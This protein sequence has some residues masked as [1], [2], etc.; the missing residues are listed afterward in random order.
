MSSKKNKTEKLDLKNIREKLSQ[1]SGPQYWR[2]LEEIAETDGF[3]DFL[4]H[5]FPKNAD[6]WPDGL[7]RRHFLQLMGASLALVG[8][9]GCTQQPE[10]RIVPF[11]K[12]PEELIPGKPLFYATA[13]PFYGYAQGLLAESHDGRPTK[14]EGNPRHPASQGATNLFAQASV[15]DLYDPD[16]IDVIMQG[17]RVRTWERFV[18]ELTSE[19]ERQRSTGGKG[20]C[21]L[22]ET[23]TSPT[24]AAQISQLLERL[25]EARWVQYEPI[26]LDSLR[27]GALQAFGE[28]LNTVYRFDKADVVLSLDA[29]FM[30]SGP[31]AVRYARD[32]SARRKVE[33]NGTQP[34]RFYMIESAPTVTATLA[35][36]RLAVRPSQVEKLAIQLAVEL[37]IET[38]RPSGLTPDESAFVAAAAKD[39]KSAT[40]KSLVVAGEYLSASIHALVHLINERL[41][42]HGQTVVQTEPVEFKPENQ[43]DALRALVEDMNSG[44]VETLLI[45]GG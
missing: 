41:E 5:E 14:V 21:L 36:N 23:V 3:R 26:S 8:F 44:Q 17:G 37:G 25:P 32:F 6:I 12:A 11:V 22:T 15:L 20:F 45:F 33:S 29:D 30:S 43:L 16:R 38:G 1:R 27:A 39:L 42:N 35:D 18:A 19:I 34:N 4:K 28:P 10:E 24:L 7:E 2:S 9:T 13:M 40:G 31:A